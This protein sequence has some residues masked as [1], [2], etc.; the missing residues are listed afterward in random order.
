MNENEVLTKFYEIY[1]QEGFAS[2]ILLLTE[3]KELPPNMT[4]MYEKDIGTPS[5]F[6]S[7]NSKGISKISE[8][9]TM[10][11]PDI[12]KLIGEG[13]TLEEAIKDFIKKDTLLCIKLMFVAADSGNQV[14]PIKE[15]NIAEGLKFKEVF[16]DIQYSIERHRLLADKFIMSPDLFYS[17]KENLKEDINKE[18]TDDFIESGVSGIC[19]KMW[20]VNLYMEPLL[21]SCAFSVVEGKYLGVRII[22]EV[23]YENNKLNVK[24]LMGIL[25]SRSVSCAIDRKYSKSN[26]D[27]VEINKI[28]ST[29]D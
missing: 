10:F 13:E 27:L 12:F 25:N 21:R 9:K 3:Y 18:I 2:K 5:F 1:K 7:K 15:L 17:F 6:V 22:K 16:E 19:G 23:I 24:G 11:T 4:Y 29:G 26:L 14:F 20:G 8:K 28:Y